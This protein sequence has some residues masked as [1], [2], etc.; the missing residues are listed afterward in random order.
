MFEEFALTYPTKPKDELPD[1]LRIGNFD[2]KTAKVP[3]FLPLDI[4]HG[5]CFETNQATQSD[6][7]RQMQYMALSLLKQ[8]SPEVLRL[9]F[10]DIGL[11]TH[12]PLLHSLNVTH[13]KFITN[14]E[15]LKCEIK[16]LFKTARDISTKCLGGDYANLKEYNGQA[17]YKEPYNVLFIA[18]FPKEF[19]SEDEIN[20]ISMLVNEGM[21]CGIHVVMNLD[22][23]YFPEV[24]P[25]NQARFAN[26]YSLS[27]QMVHIDCTK[28]KA[29]LNN[30]NVPVIKDWFTKYTFEFE[31]YPQKELS[32]L[33]KTINQVF[34]EQ[35]NQFENFLSIPIGRSGREEI[36]FEMGEKADVYHGLIA[37]ASRSGKSTLL[38]N[39]I[40]SIADKYSPDELRLYLLDYKEGVEFQLYEQHPNVELLLLDNSNFSVGVDALKQ[41]KD[42]IVKRAELFRNL[43]PTISNINEY[44]KKSNEKLPRILLIIDEVQQLFLNYQSSKAVNPLVKD[45][46]KQGGAFGLHILFCSQSYVGMS[47]ADDTLSQ[48]GLR[49]AYRLANGAECRAI[50]RNDNDAPMSLER[51]Q[52]VY[53]THFGDSKANMKVSTYNFDKEKIIPLLKDAA[54]KHKGCKPV[55]KR[56]IVRSEQSPEKE[57]T[58]TEDTSTEIKTVKR[59]EYK[60]KDY[61]NEFGF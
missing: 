4:L 24:N 12:F 20:T 14:R 5:L 44:N 40:T 1:M 49:I 48:M 22:K 28:P 32:A 46:A 38:N 9:V 29:E 45:V 41:L 51:F 6:A 35:D 26:L 19:S 42:E 61:A 50:L 56:I 18:N 11:N 59:N 25:Y 23:A 53:N 15:E 21:K 2:R 8:V 27:K 54:K 33:T 37:G 52:I 39:I 10:V 17:V 30:V 60:N 57:N 58:P 36:C 55:K 47:I 34:D 13:I 3:V 16:N 31:K 43:S 7:L